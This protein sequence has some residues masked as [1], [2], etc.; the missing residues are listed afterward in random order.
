M[1]TDR[2]RR[3]RRQSPTLQD[4]LQR[5][6]SEE[7]VKKKSLTQTKSLARIWAGTFLAARPIATITNTDL[8]RLRDEWMLQYAAATVCRRLSLVSHLYTVARKDWGYGWIDHPVK[9]VRR[10]AV[11]DARDRRLFDRIRLRGISEAQCPRE[12]L[13]WLINSTRS[14]QLPTI[15]YLAV[16]TAMRRSEIARIHRE[17]IDLVRGTLFVPTSKN[18]RSR[19]VPLS[20]WAKYVLRLYLAG[21]RHKGKIFGL[22]PEGI[23]K[24]FIRARNKAR[25]DYEKLCARHGRV[26]HP[27]YFHDLRFHDFRHE[28]TSRMAEVYSMHKLAKITGHSD[29]RMLL[30]YYHPRVDDLAQELARSDLGRRQIARIR[31][32][33]HAGATPRL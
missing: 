21:Q 17:H 25:A 7:A 13:E 29:S 6:L 5:Y 15:L 23:T 3:L 9:L 33:A 1:S 27:A 32:L 8:I 20:P 2:H 12:E 31:S 22:G 30:R 14:S 19:S 16:E 24:T 11:D 26:A 10:P 18:G 28:A 4:A